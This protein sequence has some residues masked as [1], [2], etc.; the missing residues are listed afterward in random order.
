MTILIDQCRSPLRLSAARQSLKREEEHSQERGCTVSQSIAL[1]EM[2]FFAFLHSH[3]RV[4]EVDFQRLTDLCPLY[5]YYHPSELSFLNT[6][7]LLVNYKSLVFKRLRWKLWCRTFNNERRRSLLRCWTFSVRCSKFCLLQSVANPSASNLRF[8]RIR[9]AFL[10]I[11]VHL[12]F[13]SS[14]RSAGLRLCCARTSVK[15]RRVCCTANPW[16]R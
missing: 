4:G 16:F 15:S 11:R 1:L 13:S 9:G 14:S 6:F 7:F 5:P 3:K 8:S 10:F 12:R 2:L